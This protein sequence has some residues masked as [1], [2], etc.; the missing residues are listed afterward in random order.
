[1]GSSREGDWQRVATT[2]A[3]R[4]KKVKRF[5]RLAQEAAVVPFSLRALPQ[6][7]SGSESQPT[8]RNAAIVQNWKRLTVSMSV[9]YETALSSMIILLPGNLSW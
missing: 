5:H 2:A 7:V 6:L 3:V 8:V 4:V 1:V 9:M